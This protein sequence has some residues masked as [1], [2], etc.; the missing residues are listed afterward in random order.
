MKRFETVKVAGS[1]TCTS[2]KQSSNLQQFVAN[3]HLNKSTSHWTI[4]EIGLV[5]L[6]PSLETFMILLN[7]ITHDQQS[8]FFFKVIE[9]NYS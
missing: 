4:C 2:I 7:V 3:H 9:N 1:L 5:H 6:Q 8:I